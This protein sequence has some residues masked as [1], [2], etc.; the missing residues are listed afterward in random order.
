MFF[1]ILFLILFL[2]LNLIARG[3][4]LEEG[5][6]QLN[7]GQPQEAHETILRFFSE[8]NQSG[9]ANFYLAR[10]DRQG[11]HSLAYLQDAIA[12]LGDEKES[13]SARIILAQYNYSQGL[14]ISASEVLSRFKKD[15]PASQ[16]MPQALYLLGTC[17]LASHQISLAKREFELILSSFGNSDLAP[18]ARLGLGDC[19]YALE[20]YG[21]SEEHTS[22]LQ[23]L[24]Y[25]VCRLLPAKN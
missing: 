3:Q 20:N 10:L 24:A 22:E 15:N 1:R 5:L 9:L 13:E 11:E 7:S 25:L 16:F 14:F 21:R 4:D 23:S 2:S 6:R 12:L 19:Y 18:W 17:Y 8:N